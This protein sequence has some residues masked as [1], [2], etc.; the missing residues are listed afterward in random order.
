MHIKFYKLMNL[1]ELVQLHII[2]FL[3]NISNIIYRGGWLSCLR[4]ERLS[5][6]EPPRRG[7]TRVQFP[8]MV[9]L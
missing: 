9:K 7:F 2:F 1:N 5:C 4:R 8:V 6:F 3:N